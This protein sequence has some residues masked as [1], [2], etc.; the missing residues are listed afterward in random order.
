ML[1]AI[2]ANAMRGTTLASGRV[3]FTLRQPRFFSIH[4][5]RR[6]AWS[7]TKLATFQMR[8]IGW[9]NAS[10]P[11]FEQQASQTSC[12]RVPDTPANR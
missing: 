1:P 4:Q 5:C 10:I 3:M 7:P 11:E 2:L 8:L 9:T 12:E 6:Q